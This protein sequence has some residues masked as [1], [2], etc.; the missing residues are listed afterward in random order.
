MED[1][2]IGGLNLRL[3]PQCL[4]VGSDL[5][6]EILLASALQ[7]FLFVQHSCLS[8]M[9]HEANNTSF[10]AYALN[11]LHGM[12]DVLFLTWTKEFGVAAKALDL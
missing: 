8:C 11:H 9:R 5:N 2:R 6:H 4:L 3:L 10:F 12:K 1:F 7:Y